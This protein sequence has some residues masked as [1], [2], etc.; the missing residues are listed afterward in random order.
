MAAGNAV[1]ATDV[2]ETRKIVDEEVGVLF[3]PQ[4]PENL[5]QAMTRL[6]SDDALRDRLASNARDRILEEHTVERFA[7]YMEGLWVAALADP[8]PSRRLSRLRTGRL[9]AEAAAGLKFA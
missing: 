8:M 2:G 6:V 7:A 3:D 5:A 9:I 1:I 4:T